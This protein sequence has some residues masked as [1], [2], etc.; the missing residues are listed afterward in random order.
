MN[1]DASR[2]R[3]PRRLLP[4]ILATTLSAVTAGESTYRYEGRITGLF[5][6]AC[7]SKVKAS[8]GKLRGVTNVKITKS[9]EDGVQKILMQSTDPSITKERAIEALGEDSATFTILEFGKSP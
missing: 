9:D 1:H 6:H 7:A 8:L 5:C 4:L 3:F 2:P